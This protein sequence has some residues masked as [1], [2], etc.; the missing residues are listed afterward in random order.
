MQRRTGK[1]RLFVAWRSIRR[2]ELTRKARVPRDKCTDIRR[3]SIPMDWMVVCPVVCEPVSTESSLLSGNLTGISA[4]FRPSRQFLHRRSD[5]AA[6]VFDKFPNAINRV[7]L[8]NNRD[9]IRTNWEIQ[10]G[11]QEASV[12]RPTRDVSARKVLVR[13]LSEMLDRVSICG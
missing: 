11:Y 13:R 5:C 6:R 3:S 12:P 4:I 1:N 10:S 7:K 9:R 8:W 2:R